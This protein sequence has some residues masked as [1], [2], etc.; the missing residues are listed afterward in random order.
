MPV[1]RTTFK[2][3]PL[4]VLKRTDEDQYPFQFGLQKAKLILANIDAIEKFVNEHEQ[5]EKEEA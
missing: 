2:G 3:N 5:I 1:E 4:L